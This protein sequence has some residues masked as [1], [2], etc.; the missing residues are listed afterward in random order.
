[1]VV[2]VAQVCNLRIY[3]MF[4]VSSSTEELGFQNRDKDYDHTIDVILVAFVFQS[5]S[6]V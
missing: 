6:G 4:T 1:M 3:S 2:Q 5:L